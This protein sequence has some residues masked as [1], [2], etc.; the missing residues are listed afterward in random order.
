MKDEKIDEIRQ[1]ELVLFLM[2]FCTFSQVWPP[3]QFFLLPF[4]V[5]YH[6]YAWKAIQWPLFAETLFS[7]VPPSNSLVSVLV[8]RRAFLSWHGALQGPSTC[9]VRCFRNH[10]RNKDTVRCAALG[11]Q[12]PGHRQQQLTQTL[13]V[14]LLKTHF[15]THR[16]LTL[17]SKQNR[18][19]LYVVTSD[20]T[21][22]PDVAAAG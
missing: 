7:A 19:E 4:L 14:R 8:P 2:E 1:M 20:L 15:F 6:W 16:A 22:P 11:A 17:K 12:V 13:I 5:K 21:W 10:K 3:T 18:I 9:L